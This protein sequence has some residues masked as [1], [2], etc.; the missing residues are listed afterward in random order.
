MASSVTRVSAKHRVRV[1]A[2]RLLARA[3]VIERIAYRVLG[4]AP[5]RYNSVV[6]AVAANDG[7]LVT[8]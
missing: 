4:R 2:R 6:E 7:S 1:T 8:R 5:D 3:G